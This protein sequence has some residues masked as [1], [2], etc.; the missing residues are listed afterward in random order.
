MAQKKLIY[1]GTDDFV[2]IVRGNYYYVDKTLMIKELLDKPSKV[3]LFTRPRRF[4]KTLNMTMLKAFFEDIPGQ[5]DLFKN[6]DI[7]CCGDTYMDLQGKYPV[8]FLSFKDIKG[9]TWDSVYN[10][11][12]ELIREEYNRHYNLR[13]FDALNEY[14]QNDVQDYLNRT[15]SESQIKMSLKNLSAFLHQCTGVRPFILIDEYD[16]PIMNGHEKGF[17]AEVISFIRSLFSSSMKTNEHI[18]RAV[19]TGVMRIAQADIFSGFNNVIVKSILDRDFSTCFGF[20]SSEVQKIAEYYGESEKMSEL[21]EW[22]DGYL[23]GG[24]ELYNPWSIMNY[25]TNGCTAAAYWTATGSNDVIRGILRSASPDLKENLERLLNGESI[26]AYVETNLTYNDISRLNPDD[27]IYSLLLMTGYLKSDAIADM[28]QDEISQ[29]AY[30]TLSIPNNEIASVYRKE[31]FSQLIGTR[32]NLIRKKL[33]KALNDDNSRLLQQGLR[34]FLLENVSFHDTASEGFYHALVLGLLGAVGEDYKITSNKESGDGRYDLQLFN[35][36][37]SKGILIEFKVIKNIA[38][39]Q[40]VIMEVL[41]D[42][43]SKT[44]LSQ[45]DAKHYETELKMNGAD[46]IIKYG[47]AFHKKYAAVVKQ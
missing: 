10:D 24:K 44:A 8:I 7:W 26:E 32:A 14:Q 21:K 20:T 5:K 16:A 22:Y 41:K 6:L 33:E 28:E 25:F 37:T 18:D 30:C 35:A 11:F 46:V 40:D 13:H 9:D 39:T 27:S 23:F 34:E 19:L 12:V 45:M 2:E 15:A 29:T 31:I 36:R 47:I 1:A 42:T 38:G 43:A 3:T 17:D 4:G